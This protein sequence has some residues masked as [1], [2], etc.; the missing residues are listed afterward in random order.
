MYGGTIPPR[1]VTHM[2]KQGGKLIA[3]Y[4]INNLGKT[5]QARMLVDHLEKEGIS[6]DYLKYPLYS[7]APSG[8]LIN[9]YLRNDNPHQ[10][11]A[12][13]FQ[14]IHVL[15]RTQYDAAL[16]AR[17]ASGEWI[18]VEDYVGTGIAWGIGAGVDEVFLS[19]IN[20]HLVREDLAF[21]LDGNRFLEGKEIGHIHEENESLMQNVRTIHTTLAERNG[22]FMVNANESKEVVHDGLWKHVKRLFE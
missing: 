20:S 21:L 3:I 18:V 2:S 9:G 14:I 5:T 4:G 11:S 15:N 10:F 1:Q 7:F 6:A 22:W 8:P 16:R 19:D 12:R 17:L 13:E